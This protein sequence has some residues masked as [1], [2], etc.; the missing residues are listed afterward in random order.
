MS[1]GKRIRDVSAVA[2]PI[3]AALKRLAKRLATQ[4][5]Q[6]NNA[7][8][9]AGSPMYFYCRLCGHCSDILPESY[10]TSPKKY[11]DECAELH[12]VASGI[13][14][15]SLIEMAQQAIK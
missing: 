3:K 14:D 6:I 9:R 13:T 5:E 7:T 10:T 15:T 4:P 11:C 12:R 8:L 2:Q 1:R